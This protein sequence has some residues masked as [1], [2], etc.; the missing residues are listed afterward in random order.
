MCCLLMSSG[1]RIALRGSP[2]EDTLLQNPGTEYCYPTPGPYPL[3]CPCRFPPLCKESS[4]RVIHRAVVN[5]LRSLTEHPRPTLC[6]SST[7]MRFST[8]STTLFFCV[9]CPPKPP[10]SSQFFLGTLSR[11]GLCISSQ[12]FIPHYSYLPFPTPTLFVDFSWVGY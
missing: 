3:Y 6:M 5:R 8:V 12:P 10:L 4:K 2:K 11:E 7:E 9:V 1:V